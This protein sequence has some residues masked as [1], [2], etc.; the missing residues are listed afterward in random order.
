MPLPRASA[1]ILR[2]PWTWM[3]SLE[4]CTQS[5]L[6]GE[7]SLES[8]QLRFMT[9]HSSKLNSITDPH[10]NSPES[11]S[12]N[13]LVDYR[14]VA[15]RYGELPDSEGIT[16]LHAEENSC[17]Y[18]AAAALWSTLLISRKASCHPLLIIPILRNYPISPVSATWLSPKG[19]FHCRKL[20]QFK[21]PTEVTDQFYP[22]TPAAISP[23]HPKTELYPPAWAV[24]NPHKP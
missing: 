10:D 20:L 16:L 2:R 1:W 14:S 22:P 15:T 12:A 21:C 6:L 23:W 17:W 11:W 24:M 3:P 19:A 13:K 7:K 4:M 9:Q 18:S 8:K 5:V